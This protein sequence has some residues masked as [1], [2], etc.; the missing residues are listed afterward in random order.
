MNVTDTSLIQG[1]LKGDRVMQRALYEK[2]KVSMYMLCLRYATSREEA[3]DLL[4]DGMM[5]VFR[6][7]HQ[8]DSNKGALYTWMRRVVLNVALQHLRSKKLLFSD[9][10]IDQTIKLHATNDDIFSDLGAKELTELIQS[11]PDGYRIVFNLYVVEGFNHREIGETLGI[12][13]NTSKT[14][15][16][17]AKAMLRKRLLVIQP[18]ISA[19]YGRKD[20]Q[21]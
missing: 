1:C 6:D 14:Q 4:Q 3:E 18:E 2:F 15:L 17:K 8:Y 19:I 10:E 5:T 7:L 12:S 21:R 16:F 11:L 13:Q 20:K 9:I